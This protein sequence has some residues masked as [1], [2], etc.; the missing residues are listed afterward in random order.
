MINFDYYTNE[1]IIEHNSKLPYIPDHPYRILIIGGSGSGKT[2]ALLNLINNQPDIDKIYLYAKDPY[3]KKYQYLIN[4]REKV[5]LN[6]FN[7]RKAFMEYS[8]DVQDVHK[9]I[10]D[11]NP[12]KKRKILIVF[13]DMIADLINNNKLNPIVTE[14]FIR[15]RKLNISIISIT[16]LYFKVPKDVRLNSTHFSIMKIPNK[17]ELQET[18]LNHSP[19][20]NI[21]D[22]MNIYKKYTKEP[23]S[24]LIN[25]TTLPSDDPLRFRKN[26]L[27]SY[28][29]KIMAIEDQIKDEKLQYDNNREAAK[30]SALSSGKIDKY[31]YLT[32]EEILPSNQQQ[33]IEAKFTYSPL[34]KAFEKQIKTIE[35]QGEKQIKAIQ[36][37]TK[38][39]TIKNIIPENILNYEAKKEIDKITEIEK[40]VDRE[41]LVYK[42]SVYTYSFQN[43]RTIRAFGRDIY[44]GEITLKEAD[45]D[46]A[47]LL[48]EIMNFRDK[49]KP[50]DEEKKKKK[51]RCSYKLV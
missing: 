28:I 41:K 26:L 5:G 32:G 30:I 4:K 40:T 19:D 36:N 17:R 31:E 13:D 50:Q 48:N 47:S 20:I 3:E 38:E 9:N 43:F 34:G 49:T 8:N 42:A 44:N 14:L 1:N 15:G 39:V 45:E 7:D 27:G 24:F 25:D 18:A 10:E 29:I 23:Y 33:I 22:F 35:D 6:H 16:Q 46:Q 12:I 37:N 2:N 51:K 11:Y 21:K